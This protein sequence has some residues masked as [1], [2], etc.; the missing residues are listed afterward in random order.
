LSTT[1]RQLNDDIIDKHVAKEGL[2]NHLT[3]ARQSSSQALAS[4]QTRSRLFYLR[5]SAH[6]IKLIVFLGHFYNIYLL[7][8]NKN[9]LRD[10]SSAQY[11]IMIPDPMPVVSTSDGLSSSGM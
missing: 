5:F 7:L 9:T 1:N 10:I 8:E 2:E 11:Q 4:G 3:S 6:F